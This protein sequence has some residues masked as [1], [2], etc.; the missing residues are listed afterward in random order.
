M[1]DFALD[2]MIGKGPAARS[3]RL[4]LP[5][6]HARRRDDALRDAHRRRCATASA[7]STGSTST[8]STALEQIIRR[9]A[10]HPRRADRR[11]GRAEIA[12][13]AR[14]TPRVANRL[15][16]ARARLRAG[17]RRRARSRA[18]SR[19]AR[20]RCSRS[21]SSASTTS[22]A[23]VLR[24]IIEKFDGGPVGIET[25]AAAIERGDATRSWTST[26]RT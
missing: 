12:R 22:T 4:N 20:W 19:A 15:L 11:R 23:R 1:E 17:A 18:R 6:L 13:R 7:R 25:I 21:T 9:S 2:S 10:P 14:G 26:S 3:M 24:A 16:Q 8:T 5:P